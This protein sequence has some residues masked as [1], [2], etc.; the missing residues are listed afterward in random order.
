MASA[1]PA[2]NPPVSFYLLLAAT[3][4]QGLSGI[5]GGIGLILDPS[6]ESLSIPIEWLQGSPF[7]SYLVPGIILLSVLGIFPLAVSFALWKFHSR[8]WHASLLVGLMLVIWIAVEILI[9]GYQPA[10]P[11][12]L[13]YGLLGM[14]I[15]LLTLSPAL[16]RFLKNQNE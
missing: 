14:V 15:I 8:A 12:Q 6:G 1:N 2:H 10:P 4:F 13:I 11:L 9:I 5:A 7:H 3:I 16:S